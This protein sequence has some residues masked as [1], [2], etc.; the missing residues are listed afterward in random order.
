M[1]HRIPH[2]DS[3]GLNYN[4]IP[5]QGQSLHVRRTSNY[6]TGGTVDIVTNSVNPDLV[7]M[8]LK[9]VRL[10]ELPVVGIDFLVNEET[11]A[12]WVVELAPD[13]AIS[14][15]GG[16]TVARHFLNYLFPESRRA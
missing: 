16:E 8:A 12:C 5:A 14:P 11:E 6:Q 13:L 2:L 3:L 9:I 10:L 1:P 7:A 15:R 4:S